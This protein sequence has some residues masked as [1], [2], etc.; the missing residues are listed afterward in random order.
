[1]MDALSIKPVEDSDWAGIMRVQQAC[2]A[3]PLVESEVALR[4]KAAA[5]PATCFIAST[6]AGEIAAY[7]LAHPYPRGEWP[8][9]DRATIPHAPAGNLL[10]HD[11]AVHPDFAGQGLGAL[12]FQEV[13]RLAQA[14]GYSTIS[15]VAVQDAAGYWRKLGFASLPPAPPG[16]GMQAKSYG[17]GAVLMEKRLGG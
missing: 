4:S 9:L 17:T 6:V 12:L 11:M 3:P 16:S 7:L 5:S 13:E 10:L 2:Y 1:M 8:D 14:Q 15:L